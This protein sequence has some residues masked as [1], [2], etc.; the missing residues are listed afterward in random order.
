MEHLFRA[1]SRFCE[2][3]L[4]CW[5]FFSKLT[6]SFF[7]REDLTLQDFLA[8]GIMMTMERNR[9]RMMHPKRKIQAIIKSDRN[10]MADESGIHHPII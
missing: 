3:A 1:L 5:G 8:S 4:A 6:F 7:G 9:K 2:K 10:K